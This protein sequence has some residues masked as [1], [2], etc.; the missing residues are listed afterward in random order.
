[1]NNRI[2]NYAELSLK[3]GINL[4]KGQSLIVFAPVETHE[5]VSIV[6]EEAYKL[7]APYVHVVWNNTELDVTQ[8]RYIQ[9]DAYVVTPEWEAEGITKM[10]ENGA[11]ILT[12]G[13]PNPSVFDGISSEKLSAWGRKRSKTMKKLADLRMNGS[14][15]FAVISVPTEGWAST[16]YPNKSL[17]EAIDLLWED[18]FYITKSDHENPIE[19]WKNHR[20]KLKEKVSF[21]NDMQFETLIYEG[22]GTNLTIKLHENHE[23][24]GGSG[25]LQSGLEIVPNIP[26]EEVFTAPQKD[27]VNGVVQSTLPLNYN[28]TLIN[29]FTLRFENGKVV[30]ALAKQGEDVLL[31]MLDTDEG[32]AY[33][34]EVALVPQ[35]SPIA[36]KKTIYYNT[37]YDENASCHLALGRA[38][39][40]S[41][42]GALKLTEA[43]LKNHNVNMSLIHVDFMIGNEHLNVSGLTKSGESVQLL[44]NGLWVI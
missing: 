37:L 23:W 24:I 8:M 38:Y 10:A 12:I 9:Q 35:D 13:A 40:M 5:F 15:S 21:L 20:K 44:K 43:E 39:P 11:A 28:G 36:R 27:G 34:G 32:A 33:L 6:V 42:K 4:Q 19:T 25:T 17:P 14:V 22:P 30:E 7:G 29:D 31:Q 3:I 1:M 2:K 16:V 41:V 26:T 18:V